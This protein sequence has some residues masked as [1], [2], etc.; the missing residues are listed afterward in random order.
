MEEDIDIQRY[1]NED[2]LSKEITLLI[3]GL[4]PSSKPKW[5][6]MTPQHMLEHLEG[7]FKISNGEIKLDK[8]RVDESEL[9]DK[10]KYLMSDS[11]MGKN[12]IIGKEQKLTDLK[13]TSFDEAKVNF[14]KILI[15]FFAHHDKDKEVVYLH[16]AFG[17]LNYIGWL[18][19]H[20]KHVKHHF[21]Q[22]GLVGE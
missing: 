17:N 18:Q 10:I 8:L 2:Y 3:N 4:T 13:Y 6:I 14:F 12:I 22:F 20:A 5:G 15:N 16:P 21:E 19:F 11:P 9:G 1:A 7:S